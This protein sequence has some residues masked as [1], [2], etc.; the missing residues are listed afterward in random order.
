VT[1]RTR[2]AP[3]RTLATFSALT[4]LVAVVAAQG[5]GSWR[6][7]QFAAPI[8]LP[9]VSQPTFAGFV[10]PPGLGALAAR[11]W[12]DVRIVDDRDEERPFVIRVRAGGR[13]IEWRD[14]RVLDPGFV[15][16]KH[17]QFV[18]DVGTPT[19]VHNRLRLDLV[20]GSD[21]L[22]WLEVAVGTDAVT[23][24][25]IR[26]RA[27]IYSLGQAGLDT[28]LQ[29]SYPDSTAR[30]VRVRLLDGTRRFRVAGARVAEEVETPTELRPADIRFV[31]AT[32]PAPD[33]S[34][35][36]SDPPT[37]GLSLGELRF[38]TSEPFFERP[39]LV[40]VSEAGHTWRRAMAGQISRAQER[41]RTVVS[42]TVRVG[43][44]SA[45]RW[46]VTIYNRS[47][48]PLA[49]LKI[50]PFDTPR[51]IVFRQEPDRRYRVLYGNSRAQRPSY[52]LPRQVDDSTFDSAANGTVGPG[53][54]KADYRDPRPFT[55]QHPVILWA[56]VGLV[57]LVLG[58]VAV[59]TLKG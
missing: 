42:T 4:M 18:L 37:P 24:Q 50:L 29:A 53:V 9:P 28:W 40:E 33:R 32:P 25:V 51:R 44:A 7:W 11:D 21:F 1:V 58:G 10:V 5:A 55:E 48:R 57:I 12:A 19:R 34:V 16:N 41:S 15:P 36:E 46:R 35:W 2:V 17:M 59:R 27:P 38:E 23:W 56:V 22:T 3:N 13:S 54:A 31:A 52:D 30:Y 43:T 6:G 39:V 14:V 26:E 8:D 45:S 20:P 47:D 49:D